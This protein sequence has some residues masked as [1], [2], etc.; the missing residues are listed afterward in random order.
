MK[1]LPRNRQQGVALVV[2]LILL[3][4]LALIGIYAA[5]TGSLELRMA[6]NMQ[7]AYDSFQSAEAGIAAVVSLARL[8]P[9]PF[10]GDDED[11][12]FNGAD[13]PL[14]QLNDGQDSVTATV[15]LIL[16][17]AVC[18]RSELASSTDLIACDHYRVEA[19]HV[20]DDARATVDQGVV[21]SVIGSATL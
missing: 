4:V 3:T 16:L 17:G 9:D 11:E 6:R 2:A 15:E 5:A 10:T 19:E 20:S 1:S 13:D 8:G 21:K 14:E 7:D 12:P 18:P